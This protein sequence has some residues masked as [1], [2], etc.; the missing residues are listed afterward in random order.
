MSSSLNRLARPGRLVVGAL[1][2][3]VSMTACDAVKPTMERSKEYALYDYSS[4]VRW[5]DWDAAYDFV[6]PKYKK[7]HPMTSIDRERFKQVEIANYEVIAKADHGATIDQ[8]V[9]LEIINRHTQVPRTITFT[10]HWSYDQE[11]KKWSLETGLPDITQQ[12]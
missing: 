1:A 12:D 10:E 2:L 4:A 11:K 6:D 3:V 8:Q 5:G 9:K 7:D